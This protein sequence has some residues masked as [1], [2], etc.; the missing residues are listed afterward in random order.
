[1]A[2]SSYTECTSTTSNISFMASV[3]P[4]GKF[5]IDQKK[6]RCCFVLLNVRTACFCIAIGDIILN[7][8]SFLACIIY[9]F[10]HS[11]GKACWAAVVIGILFF[12]FWTVLSLLL[13]YGLVR[14]RTIFIVIYGCCKLIEI[15]L[16]L[17]T[18]ILE[19]MLWNQLTCLKS[20]FGEE[21]KQ[22]TPLWRAIVGHVRHQDPRMVSSEA[23]DIVK[24]CKKSE[25]P[26]MDA[27]YHYNYI[28]YLFVQNMEIPLEKAVLIDVIILLLSL[29]TLAVVVATMVQAYHYIK[30]YNAWNDLALINAMNH[31]N[32]DTNMKQ[33]PQPSPWI[34]S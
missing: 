15:L 23:T 22:N 32:L 1:M 19:A 20:N 31:R 26:P 3:L 30:V 8:S 28:L 21:E 13:I 5:G 2:I 12:A 24:R 7:V 10:Y 14:Y 6:F 18:I 33:W 27:F 25:L 4:A 29:I 17:I 34:R 9:T 11:C 16:V